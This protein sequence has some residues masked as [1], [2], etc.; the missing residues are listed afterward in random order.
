LF[1]SDESE[2]LN[3]GYG[4]VAAYGLVYLGI[5]TAQALYWHSNARFVTMLRGTLVTAV[6]SK[7]TEVSI[8]ASDNAAAI[9]LMS[10]D[11]SVSICMAS[12][13]STCAKLRC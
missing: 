9:T 6:F 3:V 1:L 2:S 7:A 13:I 4:L 12:Q 10:T 5:A 8:A 11:V